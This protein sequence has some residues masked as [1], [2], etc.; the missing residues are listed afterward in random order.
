MFEI[1][2]AAYFGRVVPGVFD[3]DTYL[4]ISGPATFF[5]S[6]IE[7]FVDA[8]LARGDLFGLQSPSTLLIL[9]HRS[10]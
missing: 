10:G 4:S 7:G 9:L 3:I 6:A 5:S 1:R 8:D 2:S